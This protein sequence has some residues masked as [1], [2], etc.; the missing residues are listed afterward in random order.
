MTFENVVD[1]LSI[2]SYIVVVKSK[3]CIHCNA[4]ILI[5][6]GA[7]RR[8]DVVKNKVHVISSRT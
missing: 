3:Y 6:H 2:Q 5:L 8:V 1:G 4:C 7:Q